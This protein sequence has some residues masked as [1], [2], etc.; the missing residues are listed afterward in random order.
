MPKIDKNGNMRTTEDDMLIPALQI[1]R[2]NPGCTMSTIKLE[3]P[4]RMNLYKAD[5]ALSMKRP[6]ERMY[7]QIVGNLICHRKTNKFGKFVNVIDSGKGKK[8]KF[9]LNYNGEAFLNEIKVRD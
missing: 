1:I 3:I 6:G 2:D 9:I 7:H 4:R 5:M 8:A